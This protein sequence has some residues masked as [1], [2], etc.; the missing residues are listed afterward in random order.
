[1][2]NNKINNQICRMIQTKTGA[3]TLLFYPI[4]VKAFPS[5]GARPF[6][7]MVLV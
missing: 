5:N 4:N 2:N 3:Q 1:E 7:I 6:P